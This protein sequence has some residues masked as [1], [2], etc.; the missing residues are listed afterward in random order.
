MST[1]S[2]YTKHKCN[3]PT[4][5]SMN[6][7]KVWPA[8]RKPNGIRVNS[9]RPKGIVMAVFGTSAGSIGIWW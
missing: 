4:T 9:N 8:L 2:I 1:S 7:W 5:W 6:R 3:P